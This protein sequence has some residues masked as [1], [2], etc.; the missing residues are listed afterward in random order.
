MERTYHIEGTKHTSGHSLYLRPTGSW[1]HTTLRLNS[2]GL[3]LTN[4]TQWHSL[5]R[6]EV[7][8][9]TPTTNSITPKRSSLPYRDSAPASI[10]FW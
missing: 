9:D 6:V 7:L 8:T 2:C 5:S 1:T 3:V 10:P 4:L